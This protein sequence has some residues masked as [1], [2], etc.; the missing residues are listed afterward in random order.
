MGNPKQKPSD[1]KSIIP[2]DHDEPQTDWRS[3]YVA[4]ALSFVGSAQ[5]SLYFSALWPYLQILDSSSTEQFFGYIVAVYSVGQ[6]ISSPTFGYWSNAIKQVRI[7]LYVGLFLMFLGNA[8]YIALEVVTFPKKYLM[9]IC[10]FVTG[11]GSGN[12]T[13]LRTYASTASTLKDRPRA[14]A[15]VTCGQA[16]GMTC[17]PALQLIFTPL[18]YPG[19][20]L[21][22]TLTI[23]LYT[24]PAYLACAMNFFGALAL[25]FMFKENYAGIIETPSS[26]SQTKPTSSP[27]PSIPM[28]DITA[29]LICYCTRFTQ[30]F[31]NTN[32]ETIGSAFSMMMFNFSETKAVTYTAAAQGCVG[33][34]TFLT[35]FAYIGLKLETYISSRKACMLSLIMLIIFHLLTYSWPFIPGH[36]KMHN[37]SSVIS[38][39]LRVGCNTD[40]FSWCEEL[41]PVNV[42]LYYAAYIIVIGFAFPIMNITVTT[43]FSKILGPRR[44]GT[45]QGLFQ[46]SGGVARMIGPIAVSMLYSEYGPRMAWNM[47]IFVIGATLLAWCFFYR[48]MIP[49]QI[50]SI[51]PEICVMPTGGTKIVPNTPKPRTMSSTSNQ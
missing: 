34:F 29:V 13:L 43:L 15:F 30:M 27:F 33:I 37:S 7:P 23:N 39:E 38:A 47:E 10:R 22:Q 20:Q 28:Y 41:A 1:K 25:K 31:I 40:K 3:I 35:Y 42:Y 50:P 17:G 21:F 36:V 49:L 6:I 5:F 2:I 12:V 4:A 24:A 26:P 44:Q 8:L 32:L 18:G 19:F 14:I 11:A 48:R 45:Q 46:V 9:L 51:D 16:L